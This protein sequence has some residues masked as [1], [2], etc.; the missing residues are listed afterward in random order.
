MLFALAVYV[1]G[2]VWI[3]NTFNP[4]LGIYSTQAF[5]IVGYLLF[6]IVLS[7]VPGFQ[8]SLERHFLVH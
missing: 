2:R 8:R 7:L 1:V 6:G 5:V 4:V 3:W